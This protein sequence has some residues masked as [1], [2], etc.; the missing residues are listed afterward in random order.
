M[1]YQIKLIRILTI[2][3]VLLLW[4]SSQSQE[5]V[6]RERCPNLEKTT[7]LRFAKDNF[8]FSERDQETFFDFEKALPYLERLNEV[9]AAKQITLVILPVPTRIMAMP[10]YVQDYV[11]AGTVAENQ[12][13]YRDFISALATKSI[14]VVNLLEPALAFSAESSQERFFLDWDTHWSPSGSRVAAQAVAKLLN[15]LGDYSTLKRMTFESTIVETFSREGNLYE[16]IE[17][18]CDIELPEQPVDLYETMAQDTGVQDTGAALFDEVNAP[19][20][21]VGTSY[22]LYPWNLSGFM[23][24][25]SGLEVVNYSVPGGGLF[26]SIDYYFSDVVYQENPPHFLVWEFPVSQLPFTEQEINGLRQ[27][28]PAARGSCEGEAIV[29][30]ASAEF[31]DNQV[32]FELDEQV[33]PIASSQF[34]VQLSLSDATVYEF[35]LSLGYSEGDDR[36]QISRSTRRANSGVFFVEL[37]D[38]YISPLTRI[39][40][41]IPQNSTGSFDVKICQTSASSVR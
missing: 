35:E 20:I 26:S 13:R 37:S 17:K 39:T 15:S 28:V 6:L 5:F 4:M 22:S 25:S 23:S 2:I 30:N 40:I 11:S 31:V 41:K 3:G 7:K 33:V 38:L 16:S 8:V 32:S 34:F 36:V 27:L 29:W 14:Q 12:Q 21:L 1:S 10:S 24:E 9:L 19:V 18:A